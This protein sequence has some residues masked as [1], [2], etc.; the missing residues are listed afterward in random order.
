M[1]LITGGTG[2]VGARL[3]FDLLKKG[4]GVRC[5][6]RPTS[7]LTFTKDVFQ[8][9]DPE[10]GHLLFQKIDWVEADLLD[11]HQLEGALWG[12]E[13]VYH[14]AALVSYQRRDRKK[15]LD[16]NVNGTANVV[17]QCLASNVKALCFISSVAALGSP[18]ENGITD[19][20]SKWNRNRVKS[21][22]AL[23]KFLSEREAWRGCGEGLDVAVVNPSVILGPAKPDQSS[24]SLIDLLKKG[25]P[26]YPP[27]K[28]GF[29]DVRDVSRIS[30]E[31]MQNKIFQERF[32]LNS[33]NLTYK[34][35]L[36][37]AAEIF[38]NS[39]P[40]IQVGSW[41]L[42]IARIGDYLSSKFLGK[43]PKITSETARSAAGINYF[44]NDKIKSVLKTEFIPVRE[45][46]LYYSQF[47]AG[48][49]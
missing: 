6:K 12:I 42:E 17:N 4:E 3:A 16:V 10:K 25:V 43:E 2:I 14:T 48:P 39:N 30:I 40:R 27:G 9:Y 29:V 37:M 49:D 28:T 11:I 45:S 33:E 41:A 26:Y 5:T 21:Q 20:N 7:D 34:Q 13:C 36:S 23:S 1:N 15:I 46:L 38:H 8:F 32:V 47:L 35:I 18:N 22:Y 24:G 19:E 44:S 31:L